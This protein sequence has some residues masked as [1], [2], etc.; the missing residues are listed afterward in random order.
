MTNVLEL[1]IW[2]DNDIVTNVQLL[3][4]KTWTHTV[5]VC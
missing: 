4:E 3:L 5:V 2:K 1:Q